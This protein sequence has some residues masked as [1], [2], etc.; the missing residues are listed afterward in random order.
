MDLRRL[1]YFVAVAESLHFGRAAARLHMS[2]PPL[3]RQ[4]QQLEAELGAALFRR[5][6]RKVDLTEA[7]A[8]L[9]TEAPRL[10]AD[11]ESIGE[12]VRRVASG[13]VGHLVLGFVSAVD[14]SILPSLLSAYRQAFPDVTLDLRELTTDVQ[15]TA[16]GEDRIDAGMLLAP[17]DDDSLLTLPL[18][19]EPLIAALA[20]TDVLAKGRGPLSL[21]ALAA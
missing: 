21:G 6:K 17:V 7:G 9:L 20:A 12:R 11:A 16:L 3:S 13:E 8:H 2:Q 4:I 15:Q 19:R 1:R 10:L 5:S 14:Y 18:L